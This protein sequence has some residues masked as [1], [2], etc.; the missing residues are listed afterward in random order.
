MDLPEENVADYP[1][2]PAIEPFAGHIRVWFAGLLVAET[3]IS[4]RILETFHPPTYYLPRAAFFPGVLV[5][6]GGR[7]TTCEWKGVARYFDLVANGRT[8]P[9]IA[10]SYPDPTAAFHAIADAVA[11]YAEPLDRIEIDDIAVLPQPGNFYG[12]WVTPN[13]K[14]P[15]KGA[16][17]TLHW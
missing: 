14:G 1:R 6:S 17:G 10:W 13:V 11:I 8:A 3:Q 16:P 12:G 5:D 9:R 15:I 7:Q 4:H 2:P